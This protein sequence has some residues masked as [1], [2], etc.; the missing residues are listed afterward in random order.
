[1]K[2]NSEARGFNRDRLQRIDA[3]LQADVDARKIPGAAVLIARRGEIAYW[4]AFGFRDREAN[5]T[6]ERNDIFRIASMTK[7]ITSVALMMLAE[8]GAVLLP[9]PVA[10]YLP[11]FA[12]TKVGVEDNAGAGNQTLRLVPQVRPI[13]IQDLLRHT[14]GFTYGFFGSSLIKTAYNEA[15]VFDLRNTNQEMTHKLAAL[16]LVHQPGEV[17]DYGMSTDVVGR[18]VEVVSGKSLGEFFTE[19]IFAPL[20]MDETGF[21]LGPDKASRM[22][23]PQVD[24]KSGARVPMTD[25]TVDWPW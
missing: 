7:P 3:A 4:K 11:E 19:Y 2:E 24:L 21:V 15:G 14:A 12:E 8:R 17:W 25:H 1:M 23:Q 20:G 13:T 5:V 10:K 18:L 22:A 6:M 9:D 16:P